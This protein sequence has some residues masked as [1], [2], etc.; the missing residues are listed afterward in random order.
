MILSIVDRYKSLTHKN[1]DHKSKADPALNQTYLQLYQAQRAHHFVEV[2]IDGDDAV[3]QSMILSLDPEEK[4][5]LIDELFPKGFVGLPGQRVHVSIRQAGGRKIKFGSAILEQ[6]QHDEAPIYVLAM[7]A[8]LDSDQRRN[9]YR[10]SIGG[11]F[12]IH[13]QFVGPNQESFQARLRNVSSSGVAL[14]VEVDDPD[15][16]R[17]NDHLSHVAFDFA[18]IS[19]DC[20]MAVRSV[21]VTETDQS[22]VLIGAEFVDLPALEKRVLEKS[23]MRIQRDRI[24]LGGEME[25]QLAMA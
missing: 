22:K 16:F 5:I 9:A 17:H 4:T 2:R 10:L 18:G 3:Y 24:R 11:G 13:P 6:H 25:T 14:E 7:P 15:Y 1:D 8:A 23:I 12:K 19:F 21:A 20:D